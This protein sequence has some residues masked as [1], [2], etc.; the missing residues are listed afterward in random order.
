MKVEL[1]F[2]VT[3]EAMDKEDGLHLARIIQDRIENLGSFKEVKLISITESHWT[4]DLM[5]D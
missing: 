2:K 4:P 3:V 5:V 1:T